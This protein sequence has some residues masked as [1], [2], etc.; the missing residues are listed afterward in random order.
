MIMAYIISSK[1]YCQILQKSIY[2]SLGKCESHLSCMVNFQASSIIKNIWSESAL[3][4]VVSWRFSYLVTTLLS[5]TRSSS[6]KHLRANKV[7]VKTSYPNWHCHPGIWSLKTWEQSSCRLSGTTIDYTNVS[8]YV[9]CGNL[10]MLDIYHNMI[11][12]CISIAFP[13]PSLRFSVLIHV[14][15]RNIWRY[16]FQGICQEQNISNE[17]KWC[18]IISKGKPQFTWTFLQITWTFLYNN[19]QTISNNDIKYQILWSTS[20]KSAKCS[21]SKWF[22][23]ISTPRD[24]PHECRWARASSNHGP[25]GAATTA[26]CGIRGWWNLN[27][28]SRG[29]RRFQTMRHSLFSQGNTT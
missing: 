1:S 20:L 6:T 21:L 13:S 5:F 23:Q 3:N 29:A 24:L 2:Q 12:I 14:D 27:E 11:I 10:R 19:Y 17:L 9:G 16:S 15:G 7:E 18:H 22:P 8:V 4:T 26:P 25:V 28:V